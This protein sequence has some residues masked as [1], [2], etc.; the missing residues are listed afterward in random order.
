MKSL[1]QLQIWGEKH[2]PKW[3]DIIRIILGLALVMKGYSFI[4][5]TDALLQIMEN[6]RFPWVSLTMAHYVAFAHLVGG[7]LI[8]V[9]ILTRLAVLVQLP[10]II[11]AII[12]VNSQR[13]FFSGNSELMYSVVILVLLIIFLIIGSGP[14]SVD[15]SWR[16]NNVNPDENRTQKSITVPTFSL[17][18]FDCSI[19][20]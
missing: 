15:E 16:R 3:L 5:N 14:W 7:F 20:N 17:F 13:G 8:C 12:Y 1:Q 4:R 9:G 19:G 2:H 10:V 18:N 11:G 6:S